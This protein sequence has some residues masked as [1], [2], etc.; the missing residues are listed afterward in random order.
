MDILRR[1]ELLAKAKVVL[2][3]GEVAN[4]ADYG[5]TLLRDMREND[6]LLVVEVLDMRFQNVTTASD[7]P[8]VL[9]LVITDAGYASFKRIRLDTIADPIRDMLSEGTF[10]KHSRAPTKY[11]MDILR[12]VVNNSYAILRIRTMLPIDRSG[13]AGKKPKV[14]PARTDSSA[15]LEAC[16]IYIPCILEIPAVMKN[17]VE[18]EDP[19]RAIIARKSIEGFDVYADLQKREPADVVAMLGLPSY[20]LDSTEDPADVDLQPEPEPPAIQ[21]EESLQLTFMEYDSP[22]VEENVDDMRLID[23]L[24]EGEIVLPSGEVLG[25]PQLQSKKD[26]KM[27]LA[28]NQSLAIVMLDDSFGWTEPDRVRVILLDTAG[29]AF[30]FMADMDDVAYLREYAV[31]REQNIFAGRPFSREFNSAAFSPALRALSSDWKGFADMNAMVRVFPTENGGLTFQDTGQRAEIRLNIRFVFPVLLDEARARKVEPYNIWNKRKTDPAMRRLKDLPNG[32]AGATVPEMVEM[33]GKPIPRSN[34]PQPPAT[35]AIDAEPMSVEDEFDVEPEVMDA[36]DNTSSEVS[37]ATGEDDIATRIELLRKG[38]VVLEDGTVVDIPFVQLDEIDSMSKD[39]QMLMFVVLTDKFHGDYYVRIIVLDEFGKLMQYYSD[40]YK[41]IGSKPKRAELGMSIFSQKKASEHGNAF[42]L[43]LLGLISTVNNLHVSFDIWA[44]IAQLNAAVDV[45]NDASGNPTLLSR[46]TAF[47]SRE[48]VRIVF[49]VTID[50]KRPKAGKMIW[51]S[52]K[53]LAASRR[54]NFKS[55]LGG[56]VRVQDVIAE[57][58]RAKKRAPRPRSRRGTSETPIDY[59]E[60]QLDLEYREE[61]VNLYKMLRAGKIK[62]EDGTVLDIPHVAGLT[63]EQTLY[64][65]PME[66][67]IPA[68]RELARKRQLLLFIIWENNFDDKWDSLKIILDNDG[69]IYKLK[70]KVFEDIEEYER[71]SETQMGIYAPTASEPIDSALKPSILGIMDENTSFYRNVMP[72]IA[73]LFARIA[74]YTDDQGNKTLKPNSASRPTFMRSKLVFPVLIPDEHMREE[75]PKDGTPVWSI[76]DHQRATKIPFNANG[77]GRDVTVLDM[78]QYLS[79]QSQHQ[80]AGDVGSIEVTVEISPESARKIRYMFERRDHVR[81]VVA[82]GAVTA[83]QPP[84]VFEALWAKL[85]GDTHT[86]LGN[87][88]VRTD[89]LQNI[90]RISPDVYSDESATGYFVR[91]LTEEEQGKRPGDKRS[92]TEYKYNHP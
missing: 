30:Q 32:G 8:L 39:R 67:E 19:S 4:L 37:V 24:R 76:L 74:V 70:T 15:A 35:D 78:I 7:N 46:G 44:G 83:S 77:S 23:L 80:P 43:E 87:F 22:R 55:G 34:K 52:K 86:N 71:K 14:A 65:T 5:T 36:I 50:K 12:P 11:R 63:D 18:V 81:F 47:R 64:F 16:T 9:L 59:G 62:L 33:V 61:N 49:P 51:N 54:L 66:E 68:V 58:N 82:E 45:F 27:V 48:N 26:M 73:Q 88:L 56:S 6:D 38:R 29:G 60:Q 17:K 89:L 79:G 3:S 72:A 69:H 92:R 57:I 85:A 20:I 53:I 41:S 2:D 31:S 28:G 1:I 40:P 90:V 84:F 91:A 25:V 75:G 21:P 13:G 42:D 10:Y